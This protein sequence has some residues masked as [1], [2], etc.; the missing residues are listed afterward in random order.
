MR[1]V[2]SSTT[3]F[4]FSAFVIALLG[5]VAY[6][7]LAIRAARQVTAELFAKCEVE[8]DTTPTSL[9]PAQADV[10]IQVQDPNFWSH[11]GVDWDAPLATTITQSIVKQLYF[12]SFHPGFA[13]IKQSLVAEFAVSPLV[14]KK[15]Q[16][17]AFSDLVYL[18]N[19]RG[20]QVHGFSDGAQAWFDKPLVALDSDEYLS[21]LAMMVSPNTLTPGTQANFARVARIKKL[22]AG[23]CSR[24]GLADVY[25]VACSPTES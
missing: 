20:K 11:H 21:L 1:S 25:F 22:I 3:K 19:V 9:S 4:A 2:L 5:F 6:E 14:T 18:G 16:L 8:T 24:H 15:A 13:K 7:A 10:L 17:L 12:K 23:N